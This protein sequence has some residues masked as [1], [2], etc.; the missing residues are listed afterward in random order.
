MRGRLIWL[1]V[2]LMVALFA[3]YAGLSLLIVR[4]ALQAERRPVEGHPAQFGLAYEDVSF[5]SRRGDLSLSGWYLPAGE[6]LGSVILVHGL[7]SQR[8]GDYAVVLAGDLVR[9][10][11]NVLLFDLRG[12]GESEGEKVTA[13]Y[14]ERYDVLGAYD[15][16][17]R[18]GEEPG[19]VAVLGRSLGAGTAI[20]SAALEPGIAAT[21]ADSPF[22]DLGDLMAQETAK[23]TVLPEWLVPIFSPSGRLIARVVYDVDLGAL[24]PER[25]ARAIAHPVLV[26]HGDADERIPHSHGVRIAENAPAGSELWTLPGVGHVQAF[27]AAPAEYVERVVTYLRTRFE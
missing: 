11:Y 19:R 26:I 20:L 16:L 7:D 25:A 24:R 27:Q 10:G 23:R 14:H 21:I 13:G 22:A 2:V 5:A 12:H 18:R 15:F 17:V 8:G 4:A 6:D 9:E 1:A 3:V